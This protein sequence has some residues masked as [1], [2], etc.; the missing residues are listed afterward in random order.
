MRGELF[1]YFKPSENIVEFMGAR[2]QI[3]RWHTF[4]VSGWGV[5]VDDE[6]QAW[7]LD[8]SGTIVTKPWGKKEHK[9]YSRSCK[10]YRLRC[11]LRRWL[12]KLGKLIANG[13][14]LDWCWPT[15]VNIEV[16]Y[17]YISSGGGW[18]YS[19]GKHKS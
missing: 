9:A 4:A 10:K 8:Y 1:V 12:R 16:T 2:L 6:T 7:N 19:L 5:T 17:C 3:P 15:E 11:L 14:K 18:K 13:L